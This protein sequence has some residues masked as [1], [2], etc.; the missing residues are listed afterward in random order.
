LLYFTRYAFKSD[1][2]SCGFIVDGKWKDIIVNDDDDDQEFY[3]GYRMLISLFYNC[4]AF[5]ICIYST[6]VSSSSYSVRGLKVVKA[7]VEQLKI[8]WN[9][10][11]IIIMRE[12]CANHC[13]FITCFSYS[14]LYCSWCEKVRVVKVWIGNIKMSQIAGTIEMGIII[15]SLRVS[16]DYGI[17]VQ[18]V[19]Q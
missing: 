18:Y 10:I 15:C 12:S 6:C 17:F 8:Q 1:L 4:T 7:S 5:I 11:P 19:I 14:V 13:L 3:F 2:F 9:I 16:Y